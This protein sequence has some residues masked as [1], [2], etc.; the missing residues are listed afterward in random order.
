MKKNNSMSALGIEK[1]WQ[2]TL[3]KLPDKMSEEDIHSGRLISQ[4]EIDK[5]DAKWTN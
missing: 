2:K 1:E 3:T 5:E 4:T